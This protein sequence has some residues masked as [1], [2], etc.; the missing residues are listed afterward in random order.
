MT[1]RQLS[2]SAAAAR[3]QGLAMATVIIITFTVSSL[4]IALTSLSV[5]ALGKA[6]NDEDWQAALNAANA[7]VSDYLAR[8]NE[9]PDYWQYRNE[10]AEYSSTSEGGLPPPP[11]EN[12]AFTGW[13]EI[14]GEEYGPKVSEFRYEVDNSQYRTDGVIRLQSSGRVGNVVRTVETILRRRAFIDYLYFTDRETMDP[15]QNFRPDCDEYF[16]TGRPSSCVDINFIRGDEINGPL[17]S[18]DAI[19]TCGDPKFNDAVTTS[20]PTDQEVRHRTNESYW[21]SRRGSPEFVNGPPRYVS[22]LTL[23]PSNTVISQQVNTR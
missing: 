18:N 22:K 17:H 7:G 19:L 6:A 11:E 10:D 23:P 8:L 4:A 5:S 14:D 13:K 1:E 9:T 16:Y 20:W 15:L 2:I 21:C 3:D 12:L